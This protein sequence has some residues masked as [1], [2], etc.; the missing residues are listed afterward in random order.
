[1]DAKGLGKVCHSSFRQQ[2]VLKERWSKYTDGAVDDSIY[3]IGM[4]SGH[5]SPVTWMILR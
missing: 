1:M 2:V 4:D 5:R 3:A